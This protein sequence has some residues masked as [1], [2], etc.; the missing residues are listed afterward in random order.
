MNK[1]QLLLTFI[2]IIGGI[3]GA[4]IGHY[5]IGDEYKHYL[6]LDTGETE[7]HWIPQGSFIYG[8]GGAVASGTGFFFIAVAYIELKRRK[9]KEEQK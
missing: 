5:T 2:M 8:L 6:N 4:V 1:I 7:T 3:V 9:E